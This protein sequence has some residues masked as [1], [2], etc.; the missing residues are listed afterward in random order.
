MDEEFATADHLQQWLVQQGLSERDA[1]EAA[2]ALFQ[3][4]YV[5]SYSCLGI[6]REDLAKAGLF[7]RPLRNRL[8][9]VC[10]HQRWEQEQL[11]ERLFAQQAE[12]IAALLHRAL[13]PIGENIQKI[14]NNQE[15]EAEAEALVISAP[16]TRIFDKILRQL[17][18]I[19]S[20]VQ[21]SEKPAFAPAPD[22]YQWHE[23]V[24]NSP[25]NKEGYMKYLK[26]NITLP[27]ATHL[28]DAS[29]DQD[30]LSGPIDGI[31][32]KGN[33]DVVLMPRGQKQNMRQHIL[34]AIE[35]TKDSN[36][37][38]A[39]INRQVIIQHLAASYWNQRSRVLTMMT[40]L[41]DGWHF[42]WF[43]ERQG[44][45]HVMKYEATRSEALYLIEHS[46]DEEGETLTPESFLRR[47]SWNS[48]G[49][50]GSIVEEPLDDGH[51]PNNDGPD[52]NN[53][54][55]D[56]NRE[57]NENERRSDGNAGRQPDTGTKRPSIHQSGRSSGK[58]S[59]QTQMQDSTLEFM[60][61][62]EAC[63]RISCDSSSNASQDVLY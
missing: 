57:P 32:V 24:E 54:G 4:G 27:D 40:D 19:W 58:L 34:M 11:L 25:R 26:D 28:L 21:W 62:E 38:K 12:N 61:E 9:T 30:L 55:P 63:S 52:P 45:T 6:S 16:K 2:P 48:R 20:E 51:D 46:Q 47:S 43:V 56:P 8:V 7:A 3:L 49:Q 41:N 15:A 33:V 18:I 37:D 53:D 50:L 17:D 44:Q 1:A 59:K 14:L 13:A 42:Y 39:R 60:D 36:T 29:K 5:T 23:S 31:E 22:P 35:L 10:R